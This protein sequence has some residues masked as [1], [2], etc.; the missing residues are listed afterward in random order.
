MKCIERVEIEEFV[1]GKLAPQQMLAVDSH[2]RECSDCR[3][4][5][6]S[7][8][9]RVDLA[10][11]VIGAADCP[12]YDELSAYLDESLD[13]ARFLAIHDHA[14]LCELCA[15][16]LDRIRELR[17]HAALRDKVTVKPGASRVR[18]RGFFVYWKQALTVVSLGALAAVAIMSSNPV[19]QAPNKPSRTA[20]NPPIAHPARP[21]GPVSEPEQS[22]PPLNANVAVNKPKP[23]PVTVAAST[24]AELK[25][26]PLVTP[27]AL[28][29]DGGYAVVRKNG[30]LTLAKAD[31][32]SVA[33]RLGARMAAKIEEKLRTG[34]IRLPDPVKMAMAGITTRANA[35]GYQAPPAAPKPAGPIGKI[36]ISAT[37]T[38]NWSPVD[39]AD[40]Y[41]VQVYDTSGH[42]VAEEITKNTSLT[43]SDPLPR[44]KSYSWRVSVRF[45]EEDSWTRSASS[46]FHVLSEQD[47]DTINSVRTQLRGSHLAMGAAY[48]SAGLYDEAAN[49]YRIL[50]RQ[51][52][53][54]QLAR[55]MLYGVEKH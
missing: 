33:S 18:Q 54:S 32:G 42:V 38:F 13:A 3:K 46:P 26:K 16:D 23:A 40:A 29:K 36:V 10:S 53:N 28:L 7:L 22:S 45:G 43:F 21:A 27:P 14:N 19:G 44:G 37:P 11:A 17:S 55:D 51:N 49:E 31:G 12:E 41:R 24:P 52:P 48:E 50:R 20:A 5:A 47:Y 4:L 1:K 8:S 6:A 39:L 35:D 15:R 2:I 34:K 30:T 9:S 25:P